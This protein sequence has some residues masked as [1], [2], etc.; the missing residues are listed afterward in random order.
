[1]KIK[2]C[3][4]VIVAVIASAGIGTSYSCYNNGGG[5]N[6]LCNYKVGIG[7]LYNSDLGPDPNHLPGNNAEGK[8]VAS[9]TGLNGTYQWLK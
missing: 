4:L 9:T 6:T 2:P 1:M 7:Y 8:N 5:G 3:V